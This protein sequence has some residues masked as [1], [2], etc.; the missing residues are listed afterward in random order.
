MLKYFKAKNYNFP[1]NKTYIMGILNITPDS[2]YD[3]GK[4]NNITAA[5]SYAKQMIKDGADIIDI[6]AQ[7]T[8]PGHTIVSS[9]E[10]LERILPILKALED[11]VN[12][13]ISVDT[14]YYEVAYECLNAGA[15]IINDVSGLKNE[16]M[17]ELIK[18]TNCGYIL[19]HTFNDK[20]SDDIVIEV[21][22]FFKDKLKKIKSYGIP[23]EN[24]CLDPGLGFKINSSDNMLLLKNTNKLNKFNTAYLIGT[25][26][27]RFTGEYS[28]VTDVNERI[29]GTIASNT[30]AILNGADIIRVHDIR[31]A[32]RTVLFCDNYKNF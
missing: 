30:I 24:I 32:K 22:D 17:L 19:M 18:E 20:D 29:T 16:R 1:L 8:R 23:C 6:G 26:N 10:E 9:S 25:S 12:I 15:A 5:V 2:F 28:G 3:G 14:F 11:E 21:K 27:K 4:Y 13:P 7:S 31:Q